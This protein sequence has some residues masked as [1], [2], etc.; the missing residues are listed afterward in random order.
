MKLNKDIKNNWS[1]WI[2]TLKKELYKNKTEELEKDERLARAFYFVL[3]ISKKDLDGIWD[4]SWFASAIFNEI[5]VLLELVKEY[6]P[7][8]P[9]CKGVSSITSYLRILVSSHGEEREKI[10][11]SIQ[12]AMLSTRDERLNPNTNLL[13]QDYEIKSRTNESKRT[14]TINE[15]D[16]SAGIDLQW[17]YKQSV[18][19]TPEGNEG[20]LV[21]DVV[22]PPTTATPISSQ[23]NGK[24]IGTRIYTKQE[25]DQKIAQIKKELE[26]KEQI[27]RKTQLLKLTVV[28]VAL[29]IALATGG[30]FI[31]QYN[32]KLAIPDVEKSA[33]NPSEIEGA[34][35]LTHIVNGERD[36]MPMQAVIEHQGGDKYK[37]AF[38]SEYDPEYYDLVISKDGSVHSSV[39]GDGKLVPSHAGMII[40]ELTKGNEIWKLMK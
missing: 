11:R 20:L 19:G 26:E 8:S 28:L 25:L 7:N 31:Y 14:V 33:A 17:H 36:S 27:K 30:Y 16:P 1:K 18:S 35:T 23:S 24:N 13:I 34:Y 4:K 9:V 21:D 38:L 32:S 22:T 40:I 2:D 39:L 3:D 15:Y 6:N 12:Q 10:K 29:F 5:D 37:V